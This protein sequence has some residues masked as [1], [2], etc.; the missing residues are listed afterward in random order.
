M[1]GALTPDL[2]QKIEQWQEKLAE[3]GKSNRLLYF[4]KDKEDTT[5]IPLAPSEAFEKLVIKSESISLSGL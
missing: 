1:N 5:K 4:Q 2:K 3:L